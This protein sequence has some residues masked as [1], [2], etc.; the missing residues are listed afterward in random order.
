MQNL[1]FDW[2]YRGYVIKCIAGQVCP[3][4]SDYGVREGMGT[5]MGKTFLEEIAF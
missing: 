5:M 3:V 1:Q 4:N 2:F